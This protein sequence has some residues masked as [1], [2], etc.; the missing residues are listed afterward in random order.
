MCYASKCVALLWYLPLAL[1]GALYPCALVAV[2]EFDH[3]YG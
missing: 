1:R 3:M 2:M